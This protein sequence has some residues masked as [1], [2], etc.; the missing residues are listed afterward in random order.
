[1]SAVATAD[2]ANQCCPTFLAP[3]WATEGINLEA[4]IVNYKAATNSF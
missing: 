2:I 3:L 4:A 1:V